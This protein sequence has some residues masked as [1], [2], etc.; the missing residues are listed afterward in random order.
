M[1][2]FPAELVLALS[3][4]SSSSVC[5]SLTIDLPLSAAEYA[6]DLGEAFSGESDSKDG[7]LPMICCDDFHLSEATLD[8]QQQRLM[9]GVLCPTMLL[10]SSIEQMS[11]QTAD[12][13]SA[14][15]WLPQQGMSR[16]LLSMLHPFLEQNLTIQ[17]IVKRQSQQP[18][19][20]VL[21]DL[22]HAS[23]SAVVD[24]F[25]ESIHCQRIH[26]GPEA[27]VLQVLLLDSSTVQ[28]NYVDL[29]QEQA[30]E[31]QLRSRGDI[32][33]C[34]VCLHRIDP[35]RL[36]LPKPPTHDVC[37]K[38]CPPP[39]S[40]SSS[41]TMSCPRQR[42][43]QAWAPPN[44][45]AACRVIS[46]YWQPPTTDSS[47]L[48]CST[49]GM[50]ETLWA[51]LTCGFCGCGR[52]SNKH[53]AQHNSDTRHPYCLELSTLRIWCYNGGEFAHRIDLLECPSSPPLLQVLMRGSGG[54]GVAFAAAASAA[55][56]FAAIES[57]DGDATGKKATSS[58]DQERMLAVGFASVVD[59]KSPKKA[60][61][62]G[63][64]YEALL[65]SALEEQAQHYEGETIRLR[66]QLAAEQVDQ[67]A[68]T[69]TEAQEVENLRA[70]IG[71]LRSDID[72]AGRE[73]LDSQAQE[74]GHRATSQRLLEEQRDRQEIL[75]KARQE[76]ESER[77]SAKLEIEE[78]EQQITDLKAN[79]RMMQQF[80]QNEDLK[81]SQIF[82]AEQSSP[83]PRSTRKGK[84]Q[85][86]FFRK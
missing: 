47:A 60:T 46:T 19:D 65:Q 17:A 32:P 21:L 27:T 37:S 6:D 77:E 20:L 71:R 35:T 2:H 66:A 67:E 22:S 33:T 49:C 10:E 76:A 43:L 28:F 70:E 50:K 34:A 59:E 8:G 55:V 84:K 58:S 23:H 73:L 40:T 1:H 14:I 31:L 15:Q 42:L 52:Y 85:R 36:G 29:Q 54:G 72:R 64:E 12:G 24:D 41:T 25:I 83:H 81:N 62:I 57:S 68:M 53:A 61:M 30:D 4:M 7:R 69:V 86:K 44:Q 26:S 63:E 11:A 82:G 9:A 51:C 80:S 48:C 5:C 3:T 39:D 45:C 75:Q 18:A 13:S 16:L 38:F 74:A 56:S 78:L 79:Q